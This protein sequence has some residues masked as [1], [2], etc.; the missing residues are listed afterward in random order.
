LERPDSQVEEAKCD[1]EY[2]EGD[3]LSGFHVVVP[4]HVVLFQVVR[5]TVCGIG[6]AGSQ[7]PSAGLDGLGLVLV[8]QAPDGWVVGAGDPRRHPD[9]HHV[10]DAPPPAPVRDHVGGRE[11]QRGELHRRCG[12]VGRRPPH[13]LL[14]IG[15]A[16]CGTRAQVA[17]ALLQF[18]FGGVLCKELGA[19]LCRF[20]IASFVVCGRR[21]ARRRSLVG[22]APPHPPVAGAPA[23][24][25]PAVLLWQARPAPSI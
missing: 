4:F 12:E 16:L 3:C 11:D 18:G 20:H 10:G 23:P 25:P 21:R 2:D 1:Q 17:Q 7:P 6:G 15:V 19:A 22:P 13:H 9:P 14:E 5:R 24:G 8:G